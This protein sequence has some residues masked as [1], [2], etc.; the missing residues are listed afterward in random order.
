MCLADMV[1][2]ARLAFGNEFTFFISIMIIAEFHCCTSELLLSAKDFVNVQ[3][4]KLSLF[5]TNYFK[6][7]L[8]L[9]RLSSK[10]VK[11]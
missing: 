6:G 7:K 8:E 4:S 9:N 1:K 10:K 3:R 2:Q 5:R 11:F